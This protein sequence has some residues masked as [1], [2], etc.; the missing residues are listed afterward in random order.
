MFNRGSISKWPFR[1]LLGSGDH[2]PKQNSVVVKPRK[3]DVCL[4]RPT[5]TKQKAAGV[6]R[7]ERG[8]NMVILSGTGA[9]AA[10]A[11]VAAADVAG[12]ILTGKAEKPGK[13]NGSA[14]GG[15]LYGD[16]YKVA[17]GG[18]GGGG[19]D[20]HGGSS[21]GGGANQV[22]LPGGGDGGGKGGFWADSFADCGGGGCGGG[23]CGGGY[24][25]S[26]GG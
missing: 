19:G 23:S 4:P 26:C 7:E 8:G 18:G 17:V 9:A 12:G 14:C 6:V 5:N 1:R 10:A 20:S 13:M 24:G 22:S 21:D 2:D 11:T 15:F 16:D 25:S 3:T